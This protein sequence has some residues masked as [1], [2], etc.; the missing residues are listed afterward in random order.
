MP[1]DIVAP[2]DSAPHPSEM[3]FDRDLGRKFDQ[4]NGA[5]ARQAEHAPE[6]EPEEPEPEAKPARKLSRA[7]RELSE[8]PDFG[9]EDEAEEQDEPAKARKA[10][11]SKA[12]A[13]P[14]KNA[15]EEDDLESLQPPENARANTKADWHAL[16]GKA[17]EYKGRVKALESEIAELRAGKDSPPKKSVDDLTAEIDSLKPPKNPHQVDSFT[18]LKEASKERTALL[19]SEVQQEREAREADRQELESY[20][21]GQMAKLPPQAQEEI[22]GL[23]RQLD[24]ARKQQASQDHVYVENF[25]KPI[26]STY[27]AILDEL[28]RVQKYSDAADQAKMDEFVAHVRANPGEL[29]TLEKWRTRVWN[30]LTEVVKPED[31]NRLDQAISWLLGK[32]GEA[33]RW[34]AD[35]R[36]RTEWEAR[37]QQEQT[38]Q[39]QDAYHASLKRE[40][41]AL[42]KEFGQFFPYVLDSQSQQYQQKLKQIEELASKVNDWSDPAAKAS[43]DARTITKAVFADELLTLVRRQDAEL[44][45][46]RKENGRFH[47]VRS[48]PAKGGGV[49][50]RSKSAP[51]VDIFSDKPNFGWDGDE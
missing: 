9:G 35:P 33:Q 46:L 8:T 12:K 49:S 21:L 24:D 45:L 20:R 17:K 47:A 31:R 11:K 7:E 32:Q 34:Q 41:P 22:E 3:E 23:K 43:T 42:T 16:K 28:A 6:P 25:A 40:E 39:F 26:Q 38:K 30:N 36:L 48:V 1:D 14:E 15:E 44:K 50:G 10:D 19:K 13:E 4:W 27:N 18:R 29:D 5:G 51:A 2:E 37:Q